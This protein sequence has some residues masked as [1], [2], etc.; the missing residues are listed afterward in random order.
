VINEPTAAALA[1]GMGVGAGNDKEVSILVFDLGGGTFD[2]SVLVLDEGVFEVKAVAGDTHLGGEDFDQRVM[3]YFINEI[4]R[5]SGKDI[6]K[7]PRSMAKLRRECE[8]AKRALST[9]HQTKVRAAPRSVA[10]RAL[11]AF[12]SCAGGDRVSDRRRGLLRDAVARQVRRAQH[13]PLPEDARLHSGE[14]R[15]SAART[16]LLTTRVPACVRSACSRTPT[17]PRRTS[18]RWSWWA[19]PRA[20][21][22]CRR[23][24]RSS[25]A[26]R[27]T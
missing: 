14:A 1:Y 27:P 7:N 19:A 11:S 18:M 25:S 12:V 26:A 6:S 15:R 22:R 2:V 8:K 20:S 4:K 9:V 17:S 21:P 10:G 5:K 16:A 23:S 24:S 3:N 13:G